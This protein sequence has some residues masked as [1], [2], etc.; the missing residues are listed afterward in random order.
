[1]WWRRKTVKPK[2][3]F[4]RFSSE[5]PFTGCVKYRA[6]DK[7]GVLENSLRKIRRMLKNITQH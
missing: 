7:E 5:L 6:H 1:M 3:D 4:A 2:A